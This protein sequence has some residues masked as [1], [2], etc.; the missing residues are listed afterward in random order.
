MQTPSGTSPKAGILISMAC[1][2]IVVTGIQAAS[3]VLV[4]FLLAVFIAVAVSPPMFW[5]ESK[6]VPT[7]VAVLVIVLVVLMLFLLLI[8]IV[9]GAVEAFTKS[10]PLYQQRMEALVSSVVPLLQSAH[11]DITSEALLNVLNPGRMMAFLGALLT[12]LGGVFTNTF[13]IVLT[14]IFILM[15]ASGFSVKLQAALG[16]GNAS[17]KGFHRITEGIRHYLAIKSATSFATGSL[18]YV[19]L[20]VF[21]V[22]FPAIWGLIAFIFN[23]VPNIGSIIAAVPAILLAMVQLGPVTALMVACLYLIIN[24]TIGNLIEPRVMG[25]GVGLSALVVF[26]S[27]A[28]WGWVMGPVGMILS[29]PLTMALKITLEAREETRWIAILLGPEKEARSLLKETAE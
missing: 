18:V 14:V 16:N 2:V 4:P 8:N 15:E 3:S 24:V 19:G 21:G 1:F 17:H 12:R 5:M 11:I 29:V 20:M 28:F 13:F 22:D 9:T 25:S 23:F 10:I 27:L 7:G 6:K 26:L